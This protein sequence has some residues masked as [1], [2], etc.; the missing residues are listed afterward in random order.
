MLPKSCW[1]YCGAFS[2]FILLYYFCKYYAKILFFPI[3]VTQFFCF[4][5]LHFPI[6]KLGKLRIPMV[7]LTLKWSRYWALP[8]VGGGGGVPMDPNSKTRF[9]KEFFL[10]KLSKCQDY[11][12]TLIFKR[13][14]NRKMMFGLEN[15]GETLI[16]MSRHYDETMNI[17]ISHFS[18]LVY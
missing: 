16:F 11:S 8:L 2:W 13:K 5:F 3:K 17:L 18:D 14:K 10:I 15:R 12:K 4:L 9:P 6:L 7:S 1:N